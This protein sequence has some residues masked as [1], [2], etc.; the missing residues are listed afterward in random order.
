MGSSAKLTEWIAALAALALV[1][2][3]MIAANCYVLEV[4]LGMI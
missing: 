1:A 2:P 4:R 3:V